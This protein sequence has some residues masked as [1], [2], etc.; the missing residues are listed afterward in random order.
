MRG[1]YKL[2]RLKK[3]HHSSWNFLFKKNHNI[4]LLGQKQLEECLIEIDGTHEL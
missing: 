2:L 4:D 1:Y 3:I